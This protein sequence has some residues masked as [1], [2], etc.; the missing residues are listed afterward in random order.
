MRVVRRHVHFVRDYFQI[1]PF[2]QEG[3]KVRVDIMTIL[4]YSKDDLF[5]MSLKNLDRLG[6]RDFFVKGCY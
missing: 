1:R 2:H 6:G 3:K 4:S 5:W